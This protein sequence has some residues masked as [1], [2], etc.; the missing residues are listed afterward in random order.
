[1]FIIGS[2][3]IYIQYIT[4]TRST[5]LFYLIY[6]L[7]MKQDD[8]FFSWKAFEDKQVTRS[9]D[10]YWGLGL[11]AIFGSAGAFIAK[12]FLFGVIILLSAIILFLLAKNKQEE[13]EF[14]IT[15]KGIGRN[16][17]LY[18]YKTIMSFWID[19][20]HE[21]GPVLLIHTSRVFDPISVIPLPDDIAPSRIRAFLKE[22][23]EEKE[24]EE[25][26]LHKLLE[27]I[28]L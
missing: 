24:I 15:S 14:F 19:E 5:L 9:N 23:V 20:D 21:D 4:E 26:R 13:R 27:R 18:P 25:P 17:L 2:I 11:V 22:L 28:G 8:I 16:E 3:Y 12:N 6:Y 10:W 1:M 7:V